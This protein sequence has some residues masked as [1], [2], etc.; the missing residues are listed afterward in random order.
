MRFLLFFLLVTT[1]VFSQSYQGK[2]HPLLSDVSLDTL[3]SAM[4]DKKVVMLGEATHGT[5]EYYWWR[6]R[7]S[8]RLIAEKG[9]RSIVVEGDFASLYRLNQYVKNKESTY[10]TAAE[11]VQSFLRWPTWLWANQEVIA[12]VEWLRD[13]N[14]TLP[15]SEKVGFYGM[16][17]FDEASAM[18][19]VLH[20]VKEHDSVGHTYINSQYS[21]FKPFE[22]PG[23]EYAQAV[24]NGRSDC[25]QAVKNVLTY[26][27]NNEAKFSSSSDEDFLFLYQNAKV[28]EKAETFYR[29][30]ILTDET[31]SW[32]YRGKA[33]F[34]TLV[35]LLQF[36]GDGA[37]VIVW[38]HNSH[39]GDARYSTMKQGGQEN[40]GQWSRE[41]WGSDKVFLAGFVGYQGAVVAA[42]TW[43]GSMRETILPK[44]IQG[45]IEDELNALGIPAFYLLF[46]S[47]DRKET[48]LTV[49]G[50]RAIGVVYNPKRDPLHFVPSVV[51][52]RYDALL[53]FSNTKPLRVFDDTA[54]H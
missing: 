44:A 36:Y 33:M 27:K 17:I 39:I 12:L 51:P 42:E 2:T 24:K 9:F 31:T 28:V 47:E 14:A 1:T 41:I 25:K 4:G 53:F 52:L 22:V 3:V 29:Y 54:N 30:S 18:N 10:K 5:H 48:N 50:N 11:V 34:E 8:R 49:K 37:K 26:L 40:M 6:D 13:Y 23:W 35:D 21:C 45:S 7:I 15:E 20:M 46:D 38:A 32:N 19:Q 43:G 16:D